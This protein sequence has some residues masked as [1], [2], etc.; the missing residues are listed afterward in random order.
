MA[1]VDSDWSMAESLSVVGRKVQVRG[2]PRTEERLKRRKVRYMRKSTCVR[3]CVC[4]RYI[5]RRCVASVAD[6]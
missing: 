1:V 6:G 5:W 2:V 4:A 3:V